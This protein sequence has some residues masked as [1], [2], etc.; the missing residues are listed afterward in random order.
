[1]IALL[2]IFTIVLIFIVC[3]DDVTTLIARQNDCIVVSRVDN[4]PYVVTKCYANKQLAADILGDINVMYVK[5]IKHL[6][7]KK[8]DSEWGA[9]I[10][11]LAKNYNPDVLGEH[12]PR[13][14]NYTSYVRDK[15]KKIR[16]CLR[17]EENRMKFHDMNTI[18]FVALHELS[19]MMTKSYG[20]GD[21]FWSAFQFILLEAGALN[22]IK[23]IRY[24][25]APQKYC[26][27]IINSNPAFD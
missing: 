12:I 7:R 23:L 18:R 11:Y 24:E 4:E 5:L 25:H 14:L 16:L 6:K 20:H 1:M 21:D 17:S 9:N 2:I 26:G 10:L 22:M 3:R 13:N 19:H 27:I 8:M 15:G